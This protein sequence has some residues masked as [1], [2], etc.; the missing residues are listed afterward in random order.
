MIIKYDIYDLNEFKAWEGGIDTKQ[1]ICDAGEGER[2]MTALNGEYQDGINDGHLND[3][4]WFEPE[5]CLHLVGLQ[6]EEEEEEEAKQAKIDEEEETAAE[7]GWEQMD[8]PVWAVEALKSRVTLNLSEE[9]EKQVIDFAY[10]YEFISE[11]FGAEKRT[12]AYQ[13]FGEPCECISCWCKEIDRDE[14]EEE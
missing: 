5:Y 13:E 1:R 2:F 10:R 11:C 3:L 8:I 9:Q 6:T 4:L 7:N 12:S 14:D